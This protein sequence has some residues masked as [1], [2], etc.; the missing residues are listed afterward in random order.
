M[1]HDADGAPETTEAETPAM[2]E[3]TARRILRRSGEIL[4]LPL[5]ALIR[6]YQVV[7]SPLTP[8]TCRYYPSCSAYAVTAL[9]RFGPIKGTWLAVRRVGRCHPWAPGG[10]DH[11]PPKAVPIVTG[12]SPAGRVAPSSD[13]PDDSPADFRSPRATSRPMDKGLS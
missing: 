6:V 12:P 1:P 10:V 5:I 8:P 9:R 3:S 2:D 4:A 11:V 7:I 13:P